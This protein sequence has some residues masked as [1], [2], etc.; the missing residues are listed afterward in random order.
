MDRAPLNSLS[1]SSGNLKVAHDP[2]KPKQ[3]GATK[4]YEK[5]TV[6]NQPGKRPPLISILD[7]SHNAERDAYQCRLRKE[8]GP[9]NGPANSCGIS[10]PIFIGTTSRVV[11]TNT[12]AVA[13]THNEIAAEPTLKRPLSYLSKAVDSRS[14]A[15][16]PYERKIWRNIRGLEPWEPFFASDSSLCV[17]W[18][19]R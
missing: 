8:S 9:P 7:D 16:W 14:F 2:E 4:E 5:N 10:R 12:S 18:S 6:K 1:R 3:S 13:N 15:A 11:M 17:L 19:L